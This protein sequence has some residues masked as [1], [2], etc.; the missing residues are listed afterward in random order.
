MNINP[1]SPSERGS[2][3]YNKFIS[4]PFDMY[5][6]PEIQALE[7][8][9]EQALTRRRK[10]TREIE[11][12]IKLVTRTNSQ[13]Q[14]PI[15]D[16]LLIMIFSHL[17]FPDPRQIDRLLFV[18]RHWY[19]VVVNTP[20]LWSVIHVSLRP[21]TQ[22][23]LLW[24][25]YCRSCIQRSRASP[26]DIAI[27]CQVTYYL[28][29]RIRRAICAI[30][31][32][33]NFIDPGTSSSFA[34]SF[35]HFVPCYTSKYFERYEAPIRALMGPGCAEITRWRSL[36]LEDSNWACRFLVLLRRLSGSRPF[37]YRGFI[38]DTG[39]IVCLFPEESRQRDGM[40][41]EQRLTTLIPYNVPSLRCLDI[42]LFVPLRLIHPSIVY[43][44]DLVR[45]YPQCFKQLLRIKHLR[46]LSIG[47]LEDMEEIVL[48]KGDVNFPQLVELA[49]KT[50]LPT[51]FWEH[52]DAPRLESLTIGEDT[53]IPTKVAILPSL[54]RIKLDI[55][56]TNEWEG[57]SDLV[58]ACPQ[59]SI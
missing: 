27:D 36:R 44:I 10:L 30:W 34:R 42:P 53:C 38:K 49:S 46:R 51:S 13:T 28:A 26:L 54:T 40:S 9:L 23:P 6:D 37:R 59:L 11:N 32:G 45:L 12:D 3:Q 22:D 41:V 16:D 1:E 17:V 14:L 48:N 24:A 4:G 43:E 33:F 25:A 19:S 2:G 21:N 29:S 15:P 7:D 39:R 20:V 58:L 50:S 47:I 35:L 56:Y 31:T 8:Q 57:L 5:H 52:L 18:C 55:L